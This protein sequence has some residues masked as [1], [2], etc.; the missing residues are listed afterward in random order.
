VD[1]DQP[2]GR[3]GIEIRDGE[4]S[5][6]LHPGA[7]QHIE[8]DDRAQDLL[9]NCAALCF[10]TL[11]QESEFGLASFRSALAQVPESC[12]RV[13][14]PNLRG[15]RIDPDL[16]REHM[17]A[18]DVVKINDDEVRIMEATYG[19]ED[20]V[21]WLLDE[22]Q[23]TVVAK[24]HGPRGA[25]LCTRDETASHPGFAAGAGGDNVGAGDSFTAVL[26]RGL[27][28]G[29]SLQNIA[30]AANRYASFVASKR[31]ATPTAPTS[32]LQ[33]VGGLL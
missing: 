1:P 32:L 19:C 30:T 10:G 18:A 15:S 22:M 23:V 20:I 28:A 27:L 14:D 5:Y 12:L 31:G 6:T 17:Q 11:S 24:T 21:T 25:T 8:C 13:C 2:T 9:R 33:E 16:V 3:V 4:A 29:S 26:V 7:W